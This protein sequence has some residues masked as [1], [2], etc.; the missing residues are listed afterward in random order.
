MNKTNNK[1]NY[2]KEIEK[3]LDIL[4]KWFLTDIRS[5]LSTM[6]KEELKNK[7]EGEETKLYC[8]DK[9]LNILY[10]FNSGKKIKIDPKEIEEI[11]SEIRKY[12]LG[13]NLIREYFIEVNKKIENKEIDNK[14]KEKIL[15]NLIS[16][17]PILQSIKFIHYIILIHL[18]R[19]LLS[20]KD[21][22]K[23]GQIR[24]KIKSILL[25][26]FVR[27]EKYM[28]KLWSKRLERFIK[29]FFYLDIVE[30]VYNN[31]YYIKKR[32]KWYDLMIE[33][34]KFY[35][36]TFS[37]YL[38]EPF[39]R[40][41]IL[42]LT[43]NNF[44]WKYWIKKQKNFTPK[45]ILTII[46][47]FEEHLDVDSNSDCAWSYLRSIISQIISTNKVPFKII[48]I[49]IDKWFVSYSLFK[50]VKLSKKN[51]RH[52]FKKYHDNEYVKYLFR[53]YLIPWYITDRY[54]SEDFVRK[55]PEFLEI[56]PYIVIWQKKVLNNKQVDRIIKIIN[57]DSN[58]KDCMEL[59]KILPIKVIAYSNLIL[60]KDQI[61]TIINTEENKKLLIPLLKQK[62]ITKEQVDKIMDELLEKEYNPISLENFW[63]IAKI[64][65]FIL[66]DK[67]I[68]LT[69]K[70][71]SRIKKF[72]Y[73]IV[74]LFSN[75]KNKSNDDEPTWGTNSF[76]FLILLSNAFYKH[77]LLSKKE[78]VDKIKPILDKYKD[79]LSNR[80]DS[81]I[82]FYDKYGEFHEAVRFTVLMWD[83]M[84]FIDFIYKDKKDFHCNIYDIPYYKME[85]I[86]YDIECP[87]NNSSTID[88]DDIPF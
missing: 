10:D 26:S 2:K 30:D 79:W 75:D 35:S 69:S 68:T 81:N 33:Y 32:E 48:D 54:L 59:K 60:S 7:I 85:F 23:K 36:T 31:P 3:H 77:W 63:D 76:G 12:H 61:D 64:I 53:K 34:N 40:L 49:L 43:T 38:W 11:S 1:I 82:N 39:L 16:N 6:S 14:E 51:I 46:R 87:D 74:D 22:R 84:D 65:L 29:V 88:Y 52:L 37:E 70:L 62:K 25:D 86:E 80:I 44:M 73:K 66:N 42:S 8:G 21:N 78:I 83:F 19:Q 4:E 47:L 71:K 72:F 15:N 45:H 28:H 58:N 18:I 17:D 9:L 20:T 27:T 41:F 57:E 55:N 67:N 50:D 24:K 5:M 56:I 13:K